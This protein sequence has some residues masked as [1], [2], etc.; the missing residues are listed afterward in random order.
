MDTVFFYAS[1]ILWTLL[2]PDAFLIYLL[3]A[4]V[5]CLY[6]Q[7]LK[8][9]KILLTSSLALLAIIAL[10][11]IGLWLLYPLEKR[12]PA[13]PQLP[14]KV[15]GIILLGGTIHPLVSAT[16]EQ[17]ELGNSAEREIAFMQLAREYPQA[18]LLMTG[19]N[20]ALLDQEYR[21][22][23]FSQSLLR[24][25]GM[26]LHRI[27][28]ERNA[29]N[30]YENVLNSK[31]L[32]Q[33]RP[34]ET[35]LLVTSAYHMPRSVGIFCKQGWPVLPWPVDHYTVPEDLTRFDL[36]LGA[37][38]T[39]LRIALHEWAGLAAYYLTGKTPDLLPAICPMEN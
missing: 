9:A 20:G 2:A 21:E 19:G 3:A 14:A 27:V 11:P 35:W 24:T 30:T 1:K 13:N 34:G 4:G 5:L 10:L 22:A 29:R 32:M 23:D 33:P 17:N 36:N 7:K 31:P 16:W 8:A 18:K 26:D 12:F 6:R 39:L 28:F 15:D 25:L 38:L 37:N